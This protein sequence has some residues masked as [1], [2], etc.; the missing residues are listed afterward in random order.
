[1]IAQVFGQVLLPILVV[2]SLGYILRWRTDIDLRSI[3]RMSF[4][5]FSPVLIFASLVQIR[6]PA[7][8]TL[9]ISLFMVLFMLS[10]GAITLLVCRVRGLDSIS[11]AALLL[12]TMFMNAGNYGLPV[13][14]FAF[15]ETGFQLAVLFFVVQACLAQTLAVYIAAVGGNGDWRGSAKRVLRMPHIYAVGAALLLRVSGLDLDPQGPRLVDEL[16]RGFALISEASVPLLLVVLGMQLAEAE[17]IRDGRRVAVA[18]GMR[19]LLSI[20]LALLLIWAL[21]LEGLSAKL[22]ILLTSMPTA[23][24]MIILAVEFD[25][26][27]QFVSS[28][29]TA[30]TVASVFSLT[31]LL[32]VLR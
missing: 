17:G 28:V 12:C 23:V 29:V 24:N 15:G 5:L 10:I 19:L 16:F 4:Y 11:T 31:V 6:I 2:V 3:N 14:R 20:P 27:P 1:V 32:S 26:R 21:G 18:T 7:T 22:A 13:S 8:E 25:L 30:S 9:R